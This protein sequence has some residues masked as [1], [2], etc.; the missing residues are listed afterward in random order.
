MIELHG[1]ID[2]LLCLQGCGT[3]TTEEILQG[4]L[5]GPAPRCPQC[6]S[7][8]KPDVTFFGEEVPQGRLYAAFHQARYCGAMLVA[9]TSATVAPAS[10]LPSMAANLGAVIIEA[11]KERTD[12]TSRVHEHISGPNEETLPRLARALEKLADRKSGD[13]PSAGGAPAET[14]TQG[15]DGPQD[16]DNDNRK[17]EGEWKDQGQGRTP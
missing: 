10:L 5:D 4:R 14:S 12:L 7:V 16:T 17:A 15:R 9:G 13:N 11:N 6:G 3:W 8:L 2:R 1:S